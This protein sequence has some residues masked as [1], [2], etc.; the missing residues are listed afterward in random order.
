MPD[1]DKQIREMK[2][3]VQ[4]IKKGIRLLVHPIMKGQEPEIQSAVIADLAATYLAGIAP[5]YREEFQALFFRLI[6]E[7]IPEN[8]R[9]M[10]GEHGH[11]G[12]P[13]PS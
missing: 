13:C 2:W 9:E 7:L 11:P 12:R 1:P 4:R 8:E 5:Q 6:E 10:F 3:L